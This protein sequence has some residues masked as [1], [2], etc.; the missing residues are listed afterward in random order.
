MGEFNRT[1]CY[2]ATVCVPDKIINTTRN[3][4]LER[5][6]KREPRERNESGRAANVQYSPILKFQE[7]QQSL[8]VL[9][10]RRRVAGKRGRERRVARGRIQGTIHGSLSTER[11]PASPGI[12]SPAGTIVVRSGVKSISLKLSEADAPVSGNFREMMRDKEDEGRVRI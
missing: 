7:A 6:R 11:R 10:I 2:C 1:L 4:S 9:H 12:P 5:E 3:R 8:R